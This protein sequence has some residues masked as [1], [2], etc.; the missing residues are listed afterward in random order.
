MTDQHPTERAADKRLVDWCMMAFGTAT[1][2]GFIRANRN[3]L[4]REMQKNPNPQPPAPP[5]DRYEEI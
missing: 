5:V 4:M 2:L 1:P 3:H